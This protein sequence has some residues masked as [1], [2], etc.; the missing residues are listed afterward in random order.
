MI[1]V[2]TAKDIDMICDVVAPR[3]HGEPYNGMAFDRACFSE[4]V[5]CL[6][7]VPAF[8]AVFVSDEDGVVDAFITCMVYDFPLTG[9]K[10]A[11]K[12]FW[13]TAPGARGKGRAV[14][15]AAEEWARMMGAKRFI[16][17]AV[18]DNTKDV[19]TRLGYEVFSVTYGKVLQCH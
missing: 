14:L 3:V 11:N 15:A 16:A 6:I 5:A 4:H 12:S 19:L 8:A 7:G 17:D 13:A 2:A 9:E 1:R 18:A 10:V